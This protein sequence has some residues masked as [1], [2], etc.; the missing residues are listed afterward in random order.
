MFL[1]D[2]F[3]LPPEAGPETSPNY[4]IRDALRK[5]SELLLHTG[6][7][8]V[9][10]G[11]SRTGCWKFWFIFILL[12]WYRVLRARLRF[13]GFHKAFVLLFLF[14][15]QA[16][17]HFLVFFVDQIDSTKPGTLRAITVL[18]GTDVGTLRSA[19]PSILHLIRLHQKFRYLSTV[20]FYNT[21][22]LAIRALLLYIM[23]LVVISLMFL[24]LWPVWI[25][26]PLLGVFH[27]VESLRFCFLF[28]FSVS[29]SPR[30]D[31]FVRPARRALM[32][33]L[34]QRW[35]RL[36]CLRSN[37]VWVGLYVEQ[38]Q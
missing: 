10:G 25:S 37:I 36:F 11:G 12:F 34:F 30:C 7:N 6:H 38:S 20:F 14:A 8:F 4:T 1:L 33:H 19:R 18:A 5:N 24:R 31:D 29:M 3:L 2:S 35:L 17:P 13:L 26:I 23:Q 9:I 32:I 21:R 15:I 22:W 27:R 16:L 28:L